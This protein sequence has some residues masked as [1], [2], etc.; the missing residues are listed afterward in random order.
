MTY[1]LIKCILFPCQHFNIDA[2][3]RLSPLS[4]PDVLKTID[5]TGTLA[6][7]LGHTPTSSSYPVHL[8]YNQGPLIDSKISRRH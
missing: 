6:Y 4:P 2:P 5:I 3:Q 7:I 8:Q 1:K